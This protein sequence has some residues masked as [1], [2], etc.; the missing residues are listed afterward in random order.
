MHNST[1]R[2]PWSVLFLG[3]LLVT[4]CAPGLGRATPTNTPVEPTASTVA[5][6][7]RP[8]T[9]TTVAVAISPS[10]G[11]PGTDVRVVAQG[12]PPNASVEIGVGREDSEYDVVDT[13]QTL[14]DGSLTTQVT[15]PSYSDVEE[16]WVVAVTTQDRAVTGLSN[17]FQVT[18]PEDQATV[19]ISPRQG[20]PGTDVRV[21]AEGFPPDASVEIGVGR[22]SSEYDVVARARTDADGDV[23]TWITIPAFVQIEDRWVIVVAAED[24]PLKAISDEFA[25]TQVPTPTPSSTRLLTRTNVYL[26]A[27]GDAGESGDEIGCDDSLLPVEVEIEPTQAPLTAALNRL[28]T[29]EGREYGEVELYNALYQ[30]DLVLD[31]V[32]IDDGEAVIRLSGTLTLGGV[33][34][35]PRV[36]AQLR[37]TALQYRTVDRVSIFID[38]T[39]LD[40]LLGGN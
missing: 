33:C 16:R 20:P 32:T 21:V 25:V 15:I 13:L 5:T 31:S 2:G 9:P 17:V 12:F 28:L 7:T 14:A 22:V 30:S 19:T 4:G 36:R 6:A 11:P 3:A 8:S 34:D 38:G 26:I 23:E 1:P 29:I 10:S 27:V 18:E 37:A 40:E 39:P 35:E 24:P